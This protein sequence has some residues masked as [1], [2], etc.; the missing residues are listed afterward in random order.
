ME[1]RLK[2][3]SVNTAVHHEEIAKLIEMKLALEKEVENLKKDRNRMQFR[4]ANIS[5]DNKKVA[6][7]T[8]FPSFASLK[9]CFS[10]LGPAVNHLSYKDQSVNETPCRSGRPHTLPPI[11]DFF[12][13]VGSTMLGAHGTRH[14]MQIWHFPKY[15]I[16]DNHNLD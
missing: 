2:E 10:F 9:A 13:V 11:E 6:F 4:L 16:T 7:Y 12:V 14:R 1:P 3:K 8:G 15:G 5:D